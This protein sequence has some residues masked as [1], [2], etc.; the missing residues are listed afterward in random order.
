MKKSFSLLTKKDEENKDSLVKRNFT[1]AG[2][3]TNLLF[4]CGKDKNDANSWRASFLDFLKQ[5]KSNHNVI[6]SEE[7]FD[8]DSSSLDY[9]TQEHLIASFSGAILIFVESMG[10]ACELGSFSFLRSIARKT[11]IVDDKNLVGVNSYIKNGPFD[12]IEQADKRFSHIFLFDS[13]KET[14]PDSLPETFRLVQEVIS[15]QYTFKKD[16]IVIENDMLT[17]NDP[18]WLN[19]ALFEML[20]LL[21]RASKE[22]V[23][24]DILSL[25]RCTSFDV[26]LNEEIKSSEV[27]PES[28]INL[29]LSFDVKRGFFTVDQDGYYAVTDKVRLPFNPGSK[30]MSVLFNNDFVSKN[31]Y[32]RIFCR[33]KIFLRNVGYE[34]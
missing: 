32:R 3:Y 6:L 30:N 8:R 9:L 21:I 4:V 23:V 15:C 10:S 25:Y 26:H 31:S 24:D 7:A 2:N 5:T 11:Y 33:R 34:H 13:T 20:G 19:L 14:G 12:K 22:E 1:N 28:I 29:L 18:F 16:A 27:T 17:I